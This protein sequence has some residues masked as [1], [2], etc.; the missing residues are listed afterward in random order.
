VPPPHRDPL[1]QIAIREAIGR[2]V[3]D[4]DHRA[5]AEAIGESRD[6]PL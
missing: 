5:L 4:H 6:R 3:E 1:Q 2:Q